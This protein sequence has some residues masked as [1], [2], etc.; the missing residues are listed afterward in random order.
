MKKIILPAF[1]LAMVSSLLY[2]MHNGAL[3]MTGA[4]GELDC[5]GCHHAGPANSDPLGNLQI[6]MPDNQGTYVPGQTYPITVRLQYPGRQKFGFSAAVRQT[7]IQFVQ[8][9]T[10]SAPASAAL[11]ITDFATHT[12]PST[13]GNGQKEWTFNWTAPA[14]GAGNLVVYAA[15]VAANGDNEAT[16]DRVY[17]DSLV[18]SVASSVWGG[19]WQANMR[20]YPNP[21][22]NKLW[23]DGDWS[24]AATAEMAII[25]VTGRVVLR[26]P[27]VLEPALPTEINLENLATGKYW[28][29]LTQAG[30]TLSLSFLKL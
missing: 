16:G 18:L 4:P 23:V 5:T 27:I 22:T 21:A 14:A 11:Q 8:S 30:S 12:L 15:G 13:A 9:G 24:K 2:S 3:N 25:D 19:N 1:A 7:G 10:L 17:T 26:Q 28:L 29:Q 20:T 6:L